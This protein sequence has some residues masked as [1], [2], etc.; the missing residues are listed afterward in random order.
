VEVYTLPPFLPNDHLFSKFAD[1]GTEKWE[2]YAWAVR[3]VMAKFGGFQLSQLSNNDKIKYKN[4]M[5]GKTDV[6]S[7]NG[8][9]WEAEK[10]RLN[11]GIS[12]I[13]RKQ[14]SE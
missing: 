2:I 5:R 14:K 12:R 11:Q 13:S 4:F 7:F 8:K 6:V 10:V 9:T 1:K 3:D